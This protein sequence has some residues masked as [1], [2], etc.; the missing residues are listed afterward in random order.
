MP[1]LDIFNQDAFGVIQLT[2][3][4]NNIPYTP[5]AAGRLIDWNERGVPTTSIMIEQQNG[6][7]KLLNPTPRGGP[8]ETKEKDRRNVRSLAIPHYQHDD[9]I[10]ADEVQGVRAYGTET[11]VQSVQ[12]LVNSRLADAVNLVLD[13]TLELQRLGAVKGII[14]NADGSTLY[15]LFNEFGV[16]QETELDFDLDNA[17]PANGALRKKCAAVVRTMSDNLGGISLTGIH[18]FCGDAFFDDLLAYKEVTESYA[19]TNMAA[20]L[21]AGYV[22]PN[23]AQTK[24]YGVFEFGDIIW[25]N[26][27][28][29]I[30]GT[31]MV[32]TNKCH[33]FPVGVPGLWRTVY[34]P[35]DYIET[36]NTLGQ[37]RYAKQWISPNGKRIEMESQ[38]NP[39]SYCTRPK[40][41]MVGR[42]T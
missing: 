17:S 8:G 4:I 2:D 29:K 25:H 18:A 31:P 9:G 1:S 39:L 36:V 13:P 40:T 14:L 12:S 15:N 37:P 3:A 6:V 16:S 27:R 23:S 20:V 42:R 34:A 32:D 26:Y 41:L 28:G 24:I 35:A 30:G 19:G 21:R 33:L 11:D 22:M 38:S 7:L 5:G 10:N